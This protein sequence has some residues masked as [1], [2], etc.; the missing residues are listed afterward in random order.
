MGGRHGN[1]PEKWST[2]VDEHGELANLTFPLRGA[3]WKLPAGDLKYAD[4][5]TTD[6]AFKGADN[7]VRTFRDRPDYGE[8]DLIVGRSPLE[9]RLQFLVPGCPTCTVRVSM[10]RFADACGWASTNAGS[11]Y[12]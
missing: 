12:R 9:I 10:S 8:R 6:L 7:S 11:C 3:I 1:D 5:T 2:L 4:I